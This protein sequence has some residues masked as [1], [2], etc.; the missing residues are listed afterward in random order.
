MKIDFQR[1]HSAG[2]MTNWAGRLFARAIDQRLKAAGFS[3]GHM[4]VLFALGDGQALSQK[5]LAEIA[6]IEQPTMAATLSRMERD[7]LIRRAPDPA[8]GRSM[9]ISLTP[10][11]LKKAATVRAAVAEINEAALQDMTQAE[12]ETFLRLLGLVVKA[13]DKTLAE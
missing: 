8:D 7:G 1:H 10:P 4:P 12:R 11:A 9:L 13:L 3:S 6:A 2:Y 5:A